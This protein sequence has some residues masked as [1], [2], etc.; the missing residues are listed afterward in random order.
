MSDP[1]LSHFLFHTLF[2]LSR[3]FHS[4]KT[5]WERERK[6]RLPVNK[7]EVRQPVP[8]TTCYFYYVYYKCLCISC[9]RYILHPSYPV[10]RQH[11]TNLMLI[12]NKWMFVDKA[13]CCCFWCWCYCWWIIE[14]IVVYELVLCKSFWLFHR[15][16]FR[17]VIV[18]IQLITFCYKFSSIRVLWIYYRA[19]E[20]QTE[21]C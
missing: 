5:T 17:Y 13:I 7:K 8:V 14:W 9:V 2:A 11:D 10:H 18:A 16:S 4:P 6:G 12:L 15:Y 20:F 21:V 19:R 1:F 3:F